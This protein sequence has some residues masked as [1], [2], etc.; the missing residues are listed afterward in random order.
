[1]L[2]GHRQLERA[3]MKLVGVN[4]LAVIGFFVMR[5]QFDQRE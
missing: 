3:E 1:V 2:G 5:R 4:G